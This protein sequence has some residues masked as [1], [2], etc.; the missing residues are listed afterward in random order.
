MRGYLQK[1][2]SRKIAFFVSIPL[3][4]LSVGFLVLLAQ[5][6]RGGREQLTNHYLSLVNNSAVAFLATAGILLLARP[7]AS[8][9]PLSRPLA[10]ALGVGASAYLATAPIAAASSDH[11]QVALVDLA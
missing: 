11:E 8:A 10:T 9:L 3:A 2:V 6:D 4:M 5:A 1:S 7:I